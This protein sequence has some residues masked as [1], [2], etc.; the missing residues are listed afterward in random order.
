M[1]AKKRGRPR[2]HKGQAAV[3]DAAQIKKVL[4]AARDSGRFADRAEVAIRLSLELGLR[5]GEM[6]KLTWAD[7]LD[8][9]G[10]LRDRITIPDVHEKSFPLH[11]ST[12]RQLLVTYREKTE[13]L[14]GSLDRLP[15]FTSTRGKHFTAAS[16]TRFLNDLYRR[17][18]ITGGSSRSG[19]KTFKAAIK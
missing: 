11:H 14:H 18:E 6:C 13:T 4:K 16:M 5:V 17:S 12:T 9:R 3:L 1:S 2:G 19:R 7:L 8:E 10:R 15:L